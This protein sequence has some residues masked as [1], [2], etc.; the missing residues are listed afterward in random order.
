MV[1]FMS[2]QGP[3]CR[4]VLVEKTD[5]FYRSWRDYV[6]IDDLDIE[7]HLIKEGNVLARESKSAA[8]L[9]HGLHVL[10]AKNYIDNLSEEARKGMQEKAEQ[11]I[12]PAKAPLGYRNVVGPNGKKI[13]EPDPVIAPLITRIFEDYVTG[14]YSVKQVTPMAQAN[15]LVF[16]RTKAAV[17]TATVHKILR[18]RLF[19]G[20]FDWKGK[21]HKGT[22]QPLVS[23]ALWDRVQ[24]I[25]DGR[26]ANKH[27][28]MKHDFA[29]SHLITCGHCGCSLVGEIKKGK[30]VYYRCSGY[31]GKCP[32]PYVREEDLEARF[33]RGAQGARVRRRGASACHRGPPVK[34]RRP[35]AL[36]HR[37]HRPVSE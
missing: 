35:A 17:P 7:V 6:T 34:P 31:K 16:R 18:S 21:T 33:T 29:F 11:G 2:E 8:K 27:R 37:G 26:Q 12:W 32:E 9:E 10:M 36:S 5:R 14:N 15:G 22:H 20:D 3:S 1:K 4:V 25:L 19:S 23:R 13:I 28:K 24:A 30:Y